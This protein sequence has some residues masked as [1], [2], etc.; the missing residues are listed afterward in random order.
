MSQKTKKIQNS[1]S[2]S[3]AY[4]K[5]YATAVYDSHFIETDQLAEFIQTQTSVKNIHKERAFLHQMVSYLD[6]F[7]SPMLP[8]SVQRI[9]NPLTNNKTSTS[10][11]LNNW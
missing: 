6:Y 2:E 10:Y 7:E 8:V 1:N 3:T 4:G 5:W 9:N 11:I